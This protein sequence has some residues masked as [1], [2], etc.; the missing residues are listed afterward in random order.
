LVDDVPDDG[1]ERD[2]AMQNQVHGLAFG[3][4]R[5]ELPG[6][7]TPGAVVFSTASGGGVPVH[8]DGRSAE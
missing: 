6:Q 2:G 5:V 1:A 4:Q 8:T 7:D 3:R